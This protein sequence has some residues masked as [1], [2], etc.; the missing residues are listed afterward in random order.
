[1]NFYK[2]GFGVL[3]IFF[4]VFVIATFSSSPES[5]QAQSVEG[6]NTLKHESKSVLNNLEAEAIEITSL[7]D[8]LRSEP[9]LQGALIGISVR[10]ASDGKLLYEHFGNT[11]LRP[12]SNMKL[13]TGFAALNVLGED[14]QFSTEIWTN[15]KLESNTLKGNLYLK[16]KGDP[17]LLQEDF[18]AFATE[19]RENGIEMIDGDIIG[20]DSWYDD[21]RL[22]RDL[23]W[24]DEHWYYGAQIS[25]LTASPNKD[26]DAG[27]VIVQVTPGNK[28]GEKPKVS[29]SPDTPYIQIANTSTT[30]TASV[31]EDITLERKHG[32]NTFTVEGSIPIGAA[33]V[34][35]WM[36][37][38]EPTE[39]AMDLFKQALQKQGITWTGTVKRGIVSEN[40][41][42]LF[43]HDSMPLSE[44]L[45]PFMKLSNNVHAE[46]MMKE[47]GQF[48]HGEG[49]WEKGIE[50]V[51][52]ELEKMGL[53]TKNLVIRDG[54]GISHVTLLPPNQITQLLYLVQEKD[55]FSTYYNSLPVSG[56]PERMI[57]GTLRSRMN[58]IAV[59]AKTGTIAGVSTLSGYVDTA[60]SEKL[61]FS[62]LLNNIIDEDDGPQV[63]D[64]IVRLLKDEFSVSS[65]G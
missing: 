10:S 19:I 14:Y 58:D 12:A 48:V 3:S 8:Y 47:M 44:L 29:I 49:S 9:V 26:Y 55:W 57:G 33:N 50:V 5:R 30:S 34:T 52:S 4:I 56:N 20:D 16:G 65:N 25:A 63:I 35:E 13:L 62:I 31:E 27:S 60:S 36:A 22:S 11:R 6:K 28:V 41:K 53:D 59:Q 37:V 42:L 15:G 17:T 61:I 24:T 18:E 51:E 32:T 64:Q 39:Y 7:D 23:D 46:V 43:T 1:M 54:S 21:V 38:W 2:I 40:S 45:I